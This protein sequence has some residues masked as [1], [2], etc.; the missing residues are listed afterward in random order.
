MST[1]DRGVDRDRPVQLPV[2]VGTGQEGVEDT[3]PGAVPGPGAVTLPHRLPGPEIG[4]KI[5]PSDP[6]SVSVD[7]AL[8]HLPVIPPGTP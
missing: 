3:V 8:D 2:C 4:G 1:A 6:T 7:D 5:A